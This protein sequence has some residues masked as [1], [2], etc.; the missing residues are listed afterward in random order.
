MGILGLGTL[1]RDKV[2]HSGYKKFVDYLNIYCS[3][4]VKDIVIDGNNLVNAIFL[5]ANISDLE[6]VCDTNF[7]VNE[8]L[9]VLNNLE[10]YGLR[11]VKI[12]LDTMKESEKMNT[13][14]ERGLRRRREGGKILIKLMPFGIVI[15][16]QRVFSLFSY[17]LLD[18]IKILSTCRGILVDTIIEKYGDDIIAFC[19]IGCD[20]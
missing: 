14:L 17:H 9:R 16:F 10:N 4:N 8:V 3:S 11:I 20:K 7:L 1:I 2:S 19:G 12:F 5:Q 18:G 15:S 6:R 13:L